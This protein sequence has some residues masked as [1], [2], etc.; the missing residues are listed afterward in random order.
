MEFINSF[1]SEW[2]KRRRTMTTWLVFGGALFIPVIIMLSRFKNRATLPK[3]FASD[4]FWTASWRQSWEAM[5]VML[6]PVGISLAAALLSNIEFRDHGWKQ[7]HTTP[8]RMTTIFFSKF[9]V[10]TLLLI[11][12]FV[13]FLAASYIVAILPALVLNDVGWP[14]APFPLAKFALE[15][16]RLF[17]ACLPIAALQFAISLQFRNFLVPLAVG[18]GLWILG[19]G[20]IS[21]EFGWLLPYSIGAYEYLLDS[22]QLRGRVIPFS[23]DYLALIYFAVFTF[24]GWILYLYKHDKG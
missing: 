6:L 8:L 15:S 22:G 1:R 11:E 14:A 3:F 21:W 16:G 19:V 18:F 24:G 12:V 17:V 23:L 10:F 7:L 5:I 20:M 13:I 9:A 2:L 4:D